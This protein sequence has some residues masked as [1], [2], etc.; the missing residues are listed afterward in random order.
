M[1]NIFPITLPFVGSDVH[2]FTEMLKAL[3]DNRITD[4]VKAAEKTVTAVGLTLQEKGY[5]HLI[6]GI[7]NLTQKNYHSALD[8][9]GIAYTNSMSI[10]RIKAEILAVLT[11]SILDNDKECFLRL[12]EIR[13]NITAIES[14]NVG[15]RHAEILNKE[16]AE[17]ECLLRAKIIEDLEQDTDISLEEILQRLVQIEPLRTEFKTLQVGLGSRVGSKNAVPV[18]KSHKWFTVIIPL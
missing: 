18:K 13:P 8:D 16:A 17:I 14:I 9:F 2:S 6:K 10:M 15:A 7:G 3:E 5:C 4:A 1:K 12:A 11:H